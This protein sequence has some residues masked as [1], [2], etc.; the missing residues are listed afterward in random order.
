[1]LPPWYDV[2]TLQDCQVLRG[3]IAAMLTAGIDPQL[4]RTLK[5]LSEAPQSK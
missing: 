1:L 3:H 4:P 5:L 2:D